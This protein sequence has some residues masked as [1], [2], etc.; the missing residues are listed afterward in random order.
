V[1]KVLDLLNERQD[2][3]QPAP[4]NVRATIGTNRAVGKGL[5]DLSAI[6]LQQ[7]SLDPRLREIVILRIGWDSQSEYEFGQHTL[8]GRRAGLSGNEIYLLTRPIAEGDWNAAEEALIQMTD[9]LHADDCVSE[10][11]WAELKSFL[12]DAEIIEAVAVAMNWRMVSALLNS[13]GVALDVGV[14]GWPRRAPIG[15]R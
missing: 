9:D 5:G 2:R 7:G 3:G 11:T 14:P 6:L 10:A 8:F 12:S 15:E 1:Q 4:N 13:C